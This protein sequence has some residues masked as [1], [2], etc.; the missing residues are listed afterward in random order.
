MKILLK[1]V[2]LAAWVMFAVALWQTR[3]TAAS[4]TAVHALPSL[5]LLSISRKM[6]ESQSPVRPLT[7]QPSLAWPNP[8]IIMAMPVI[9]R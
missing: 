9:D 5:G 1:F 8:T 2:I 3:Q 6:N 7:D 4:G